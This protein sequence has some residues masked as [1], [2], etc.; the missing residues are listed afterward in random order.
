MIRLPSGAP[1][2][3]TIS[4]AQVGFLSQQSTHF[5]LSGSFLIAWSLALLSSSMTFMTAMT[6]V[7]VSILLLV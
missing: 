3:G 1:A 6:D 5:R 4:D 2:G 7:S